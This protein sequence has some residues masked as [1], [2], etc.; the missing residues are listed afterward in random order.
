MRVTLSLHPFSVVT[1]I[2]ANFCT[3]FLP[4]IS[5]PLPYPYHNGT[6]YRI[7]LPLRHVIFRYTI[8]TGSLDSIASQALF[9]NGSI[10]RDSLPLREPCS[11]IYFAVSHVSD[12]VPPSIFGSF[13]NGTDYRIFLPLRH[14]IFRYTI[15]T[16]SLDS[17]ASP[18]LFHNGREM[19]NLLP[20]RKR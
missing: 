2:F 10:S 18:A 11:A 13:H 8:A 17:I 7:F 5:L 12:I 20:L 15:A 6:D 3:P 14:T 16:G 9:H 1:Y 19:R 4:H